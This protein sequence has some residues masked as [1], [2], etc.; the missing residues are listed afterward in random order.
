[1]KF[2]MSFTGF[3]QVA[4]HDYQ[5]ALAMTHVHISNKTFHVLKIAKKKMHKLSFATYQKCTSLKIAVG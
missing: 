2:H 3:Q 4:Q 1:M 5:E